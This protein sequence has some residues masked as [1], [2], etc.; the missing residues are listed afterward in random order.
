MLPGN[1]VVVYKF[2]K[3]E[4]VSN[5]TSKKKDLQY[6]AFETSDYVANNYLK[7]LLFF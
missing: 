2:D 1:I 6:S 3:N 5:K 7:I 4:L